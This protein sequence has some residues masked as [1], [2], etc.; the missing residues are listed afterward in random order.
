MMEYTTFILLLTVWGAG[1]STALPLNC[2]R[3]L[4]IRGV[5]NPS[6]CKCV[7]NCPPILCGANQIQNKITCECQCALGCASPKV[8]NPVDCYCVCPKR[9][10]PYPKRFNQRTCTCDGCPIQVCPKRKRWNQYTCK[11]DF[12]FIEPVWQDPWQVTNRRGHCTRSRSFIN[13]LV[14][15]V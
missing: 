13:S 3:Q 8:L 14:E 12:P 9:W 6:L 4:C 11:C 1:H 7:A 10:C 5:W 2:E 15:H